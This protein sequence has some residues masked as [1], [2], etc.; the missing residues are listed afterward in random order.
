MGKGFIKSTETSY[1]DEHGIERVHTET[2]EFVYKTKQDSFY[3]TFIKYV[4]WMYELTSITTL[5][6]LYKLLEMAEFN[7]GDISLSTGKRAEIMAALNISRSA[8][9]QA[10][11]QLVNSGAI[12]QKYLVD[13]ETGEITDKPIRGEYQ[14]DPEMFWKGDIKKRNELVVTFS[15]KSSPV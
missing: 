9:T 2:K 7:T 4:Q 12:L 5:K 1:V 15:S 13:Q 14:I 8:L 11:T 6:V 10:I 3:M